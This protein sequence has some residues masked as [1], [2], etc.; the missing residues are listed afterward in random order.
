MVISILILIVGILLILIPVYKLVISCKSASDIT[1]TLGQ[2]GG[3]RNGIIFYLM[4]G[5]IGGAFVIWGI[6]RLIS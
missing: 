5:I 6:L 2:I 1:W 3:M 4:F